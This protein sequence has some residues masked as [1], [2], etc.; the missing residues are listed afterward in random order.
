MSDEISH[1]LQVSE[2]LQANKISDLKRF[3][4]SRQCLNTTN[5][6]FTYLFYVVQMVGLLTTSVAQSY[7]MSN[8]VW[9]GIGLNSLATLIHT[10]EQTNTKLSNHML[11]NIT[12]IKN[13]TYVDEGILIDIDGK[14]ERKIN[15][16][17]DV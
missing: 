12:N 15:N 2:V 8:I 13:G 11:D 10:F 1:V 9:V 3:L 4:K 5:I 16:D 17:V 6:C 14:L 7:N